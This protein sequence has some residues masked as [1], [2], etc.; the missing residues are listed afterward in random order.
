L[1]AVVP[2][3]L[4]TDNAARLSDAARARA[5]GALKTHYAEG[6]LSTEELEARVE[7]I[8][9]SRTRSEAAAHL[10]DLPLRGVRWLILGRVRRLQRA[11]LRVHVLTYLTA[12]ASLLGVWALTGLGVFWPA[13]LLIP[14]SALLGWHFVLSRRL[15]RA[16]GRGRW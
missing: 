14:S 9:R 13:W 5:L 3:P 1:P 15:S 11:V 8:S 4:G 12:N 7:H 6:R 16:L 10:R 2:F